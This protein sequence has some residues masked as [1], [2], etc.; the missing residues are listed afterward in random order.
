MNNTPSYSPAQADMIYKVVHMP[1]L[2]LLKEIQP[3]TFTDVFNSHWLQLNELNDNKPIDFIAAAMAVIADQFAPS[4]RIDA[5]MLRSAA[6]YVYEDYGF[7]QLDDIQLCLKM[8]IKG[9]LTEF[10]GRFDAQVI[11]DWFHEY[12]I[13]RTTA[14]RFYNLHQL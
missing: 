8:G 1:I 12:N 6:V 13:Q 2:L 5:N 3:K 4:V 10:Y 7:L 14:L 9:Q 11:Y